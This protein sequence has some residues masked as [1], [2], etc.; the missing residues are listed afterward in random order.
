MMPELFAA[1]SPVIKS[2]TRKAQ[3]TEAHAGKHDFTR[4]EHH[5]LPRRRSSFLEKVP[6]VDP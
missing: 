2:V 3:T 5:V 6:V 1:T 4:I